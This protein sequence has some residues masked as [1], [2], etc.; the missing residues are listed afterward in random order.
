MPSKRRRRG[1]GYVRAPRSA[2]CRFA[3]SYMHIHD[4]TLTRFNA[5]KTFDTRMAAEAWLHKERQLI[6][7]GTWTPPTERAKAAAR[8]SIR[9]REFAEDALAGRRLEPTTRSNYKRL[10]ETRI[11]PGLGDLV[12]RDITADDLQEWWRGLGVEY[13]ASRAHAWNLLKSLLK[14]AVERE[15][16]TSSP[17]DGPRFKRYGKR[18]NRRQIIL[19]TPAEISTTAAKLPSYYAIA[20][21]IMAWCALRY[22]EVSELRVKDIDDGPDGM[23]IHVRRSAPLVDGV[24]VVKQGSKSDA[25]T[26]DVCVPPH[27]AIEIR[28]H[29]QTI[30]KEPNTLVVSNFRGDH[31]PRATFTK[32]FKA[33]LPPAKA[34]MNVHAL[35]HTGA[36]LAAQ[37]GA[38]AFEVQQRLGHADPAMAMIYQH[39]VAG[40]Q[41]EISQ[42]MSRDWM[43]QNSDCA[44]GKS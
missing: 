14:E 8:S 41:R 34:E 38:S 29:L 21:P 20:L 16:I 44:V 33:A 15:I 4:G 35:R 23:V 3:A 24:P 32:A 19:L 5:P 26:R 2:S 12:V 10:W 27:V 36:V 39:P 17:A 1:W 30:G 25:G 7:Q 31:L 9:L 42:Q 22:A 6:D 40:R 43:Q 18:P 28:E 13:E 11:E 37:A